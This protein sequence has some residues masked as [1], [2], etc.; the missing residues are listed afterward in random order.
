[1][2]TRA[3][4]DAPQT[5]QLAHEAPEFWVAQD[6]AP[7]PL[8]SACPCHKG[9]DG[10]R[11]R[12]WRT[13]WTARLP[14]TRREFHTCPHVYRARLRLWYMMMNSFPRNTRREAHEGMV[15]GG[16]EAAEGHSS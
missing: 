4:F 2:Q 5:S 14:G 3:I 16:M 8:L 11:Q 15:F 13:S 12:C 6:R 1:M 9:Q 10:E 7:Q